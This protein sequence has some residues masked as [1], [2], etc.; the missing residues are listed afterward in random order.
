[1]RLIL[2][3]LMDTFLKIKNKMDGATIYNIKI[4]TGS[5][6]HSGKNLKENPKS[7]PITNCQEISYK[8]HHK[9]SDS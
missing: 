3:R 1:M 4:R 5:R 7:S 9:I 8:K 2:I 6:V